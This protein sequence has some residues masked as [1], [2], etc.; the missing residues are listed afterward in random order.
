MKTEYVLD[1]SAWYEYLGGTLKGAKIRKIIEEQ[2][3]ESSIIAIA[4]LSDKCLRE[5]RPFEDYLKFI[6]QRAAILPLTLHIASES[7]KLKK[8]RRTTKPTFS[9]ADGIHLATAIE[10]KA[11]L[12]SADDDFEGLPNILL[13]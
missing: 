9:L 3:V 13:I 11:I 4:E 12:V 5:A 7:G 6:Q 1:S 8:E 10:R 2:E